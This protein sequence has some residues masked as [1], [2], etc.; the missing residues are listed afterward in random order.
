MKLVKLTSTPSIDFFTPDLTTELSLNMVEQG[1]SA[2]FPSPA[3][4]YIE[5]SLDLNK[6]LIKNP[7]STFYGR[8]KGWSMKDAGIN[9]GDVL[10]V[11]KSLRLKTGAIAVCFLDGDFTVKKVKIEKKIIYLMPANDEFEPIKVTAENEFL[12]WGIVTHIIKSTY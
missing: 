7:S 12:I 2:G 9:E 3:A 5:L 8:V 6:E 4:D 11:D 1:I 10:I